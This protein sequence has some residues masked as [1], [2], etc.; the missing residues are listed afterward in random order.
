MWVTIPPSLFE[1]LWRFN[2]NLSQT[3]IILALLKQLEFCRGKRGHGLGYSRQCLGFTSS[4]ALKSM[5]CWRLNLYFSHAKP[6]LSPLNYFSG[7]TNRYFLM[8]N[9]DIHISLICTFAPL[10][11]IPKH[12][13]SLFDIQ[14][15]VPGKMNI[16]N[17]YTFFPS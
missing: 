6:V 3:F 1:E 17:A 13:F 7:S 5:Q 16:F 11:W 12:S 10:L 8:G 4:G 9:S 15:C 2:Q 14:C